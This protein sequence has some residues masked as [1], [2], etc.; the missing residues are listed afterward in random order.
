MSRE[1]LEVGDTT[2]VGAACVRDVTASIKSLTS[3]C[4]TEECWA[5]EE[6]VHFQAAAGMH[7][8]LDPCLSVC[9]RAWVCT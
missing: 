2:L 5:E 7:H 4:M 3:N 9:V 6:H 8:Q 1:G